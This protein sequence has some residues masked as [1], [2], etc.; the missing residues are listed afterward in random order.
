MHRNLIDTVQQKL[1]PQPQPL[2]YVYLKEAKKK[3]AWRTIQSYQCV[4]LRE[5]ICCCLRRNVAFNKLIKAIIIGLLKKTATHINN[6]NNTNSLMTLRSLCV[7]EIEMNVKI[8]VF[9]QYLFTSS[10]QFNCVRCIISVYEIIL[11]H[12]KSTAIK[13]HPLIF[14]TQT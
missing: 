13:K 11:A 5:M 3:N 10:S 4:W 9:L 1:Y 12:R 14:N 6:N 2:Y 7:G 8:K